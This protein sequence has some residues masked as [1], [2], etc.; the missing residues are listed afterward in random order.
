MEVAHPDVT[1][2]FG[3]EFVRSADYMVGSPSVIGDRQV[4][5]RLAEAVKHSGRRVF[6]PSGALWGGAD[7]RRMSDGGKLVGLE[8]EMRFHPHSLKLNE[9]LKTIN[10]KV[11]AEPVTLYNGCVR[12]LCPLAPNN[13][14]TMA[15]ASIAGRSL[16]FDKVV[17]RLIS[18]PT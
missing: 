14:N 15:C 2:Q 6:V 13:V 17:G 8:V 4:E 10:S 9:P 11:A 1:R 3:H 12:E 16:G 7:I 18:D 5:S